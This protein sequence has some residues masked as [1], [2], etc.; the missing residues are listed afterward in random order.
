MNSK[1]FYNYLTKLNFVE[2]SK[3]YNAHNQYFSSQGWSKGP[4]RTKWFGYCQE[5]ID[6]MNERGADISEMER[7]II[8]AYVVLDAEKCRLS[9]IKAYDDLCILELYQKYV[10]GGDSDAK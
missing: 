6:D 7:A 1:G 5:L 8:F 2:K 9:I 10:L 3:I 4:L